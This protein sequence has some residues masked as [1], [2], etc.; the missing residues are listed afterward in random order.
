MSRKNQDSIFADIAPEPW[1]PQTEADRQTVRQ[2]LARV[3]ESP[4]FST[5]KRYPALLGYVVEKALEGDAGT[6]KERTLGVEVFHR[7]PQYDTN[8][9]PVVRIAAGEVRKR[10][11]QYYYDSSHSGEIRIE[12]PAGS[13][14]PGF[15]QQIEDD[16]VP[17]PIQ[18]AQ[19]GAFEQGGTGGPR[20]TASDFRGITGPRRRVLVSAACVVV[21]I[22]IGMIGARVRTA[23]S[24]APLTAL[25][26][27]WS[28]LISA[29][30]SVWLCVGEAYVTQIQLDPNGARNRF[31]ASYRLSSGEQRAYPA[32]NLADS[33]AL[34]RVAGLLEVQNKE[35]S[36]HGE[37][38]TTF[39]DLTSG[40]SVLIGSF[41]NDWTIRLSDQLRFH[42]EMNRDTGEQWIVDKEK[43]DQKIGMHSFDLA[44]G[45]KTDAY[46]IISRVR[47]PSTGQMV[48][49]LAGVSA[50]GT[51]AAGT[52][53]SDP[54]YLEQ[55][56]KT[57][58]R[59]W[60][61]SNLQ[62]VIAAPIVD[63]SLGPP[64][65]VSSYVW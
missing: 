32:L 6:L 7:A 41:N 28:P 55:F 5:S 27:F 52:F 40:P 62:I 51:K 39:S 37:S 58:P 1:V 19:D 33:T 3:L 12:L 16:L 53:V 25:E 57:A 63:G 31:A 59:S 23:V 34:A 24:S 13:Y 29:P 42:F 35:Y 11:A 50:N 26:E 47:D 43:P 48:V 36:V 49:A 15:Y 64:H 38:E 18:A 17:A 61:H 14:V 4:P 54:M 46:A 65:V 9:D 20:L 45:D 10:L 60:R 22:L 30:G 8:A 56:A 44:A 21:G 2:Q